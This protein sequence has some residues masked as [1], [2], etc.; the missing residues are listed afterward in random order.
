MLAHAGADVQLKSRH[1]HPRC[2]TAFRGQLKP[3][4]GERLKGV[5]VTE[6]EGTS[7]KKAWVSLGVMRR[8]K[9]G[10]FSHVDGMI[11]L[12]KEKGLKPRK[13]AVDKPVTVYVSKAS[14]LLAQLFL[15]WLR[16]TSCAFL[17]LHSCSCFCLRLTRFCV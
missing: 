15:C 10:K 13:V 16:R 11:R 1:T 4:I 9:G 14:V 12:S 8:A 7:G 5:V 17:L 3:Q 2:H 6:L